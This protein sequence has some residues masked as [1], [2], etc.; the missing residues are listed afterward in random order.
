[1]TVAAFAACKS[2]LEDTRP[3]VAVTVCMAFVYVMIHVAFVSNVILV[4][5]VQIG[6][7]TV[8]SHVWEC[9][10]H[11]VKV[12]IKHGKVVQIV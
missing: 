9:V 4:V 12:V 11:V 2:I 5:I 3:F 7:V 8:V 10:N 1:M 6:H